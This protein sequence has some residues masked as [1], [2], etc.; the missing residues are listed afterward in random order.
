MSPVVDV[1]HQGGDGIVLLERHAGLGQGAAHFL[2]V[3]EAGADAGPAQFDGEADLADA[4]AVGDVVGLH[5]LGA[6]A[7][8]AGGFMGHAR[9]GEGAAHHARPF[10]LV[11]L[12]GGG[13]AD[14]GLRLEADAEIG[15]GAADEAHGGLGG[16]TSL[17]RP[18]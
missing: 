11:G 6:A 12:E 3:A 5:L 13:G 1:A 2:E 4:D 14:I 10:Q 8:D 17:D 9:V 7:R 15:Q 16:S 18:L